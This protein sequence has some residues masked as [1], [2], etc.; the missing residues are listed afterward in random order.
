[1]VTKK[2]D[3]EVMSAN[4]DAIVFLQ[5]MVN[6]QPS[7]SWVLET[8][9]IKLIFSLMVTFYLTEPENRSYTITLSKGTIFAKKILIFLQKKW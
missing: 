3:D 1:M 6:L 4:C 9:S 7:G 2:F 8:W 5:F